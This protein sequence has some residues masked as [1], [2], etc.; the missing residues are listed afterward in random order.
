MILTVAPHKLLMD[1]D[2]SSITLTDPN[3]NSV[4]LDSSGVTLT[5]GGS[6]VVVGDSEV[7]INNGGLEVMS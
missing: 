7:N 6:T 2:Q 5:R 1:D 4:T 3:Q